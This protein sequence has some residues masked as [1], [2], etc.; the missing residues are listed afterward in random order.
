M[1][2]KAS[3]LRQI[4]CAY[5]ACVA[6]AAVVLGHCTFASPWNAW[7][8]D[9]VAT[10]VIF[11]FSRLYRNSSFYD[12]YWSVIPP[13]LAVYWYGMDAAP[14]VDAARAWLVILL[15]WC[16][17]MRLTANWATYWGGL[18][19]EDWRYPLVRERAGPKGAFWADLFGIHLFP[20]LQ[21]FVG[22]LPIYAVMTRGEEEPGLVDALAFV[23]TAG[24]IAIESIA[25]LQ[26]HAFIAKRCGNGFIRRGLWAWSRHPNYLGELLFWWGLMLFGLAAAPE[27]WWWVMPGALS[28]TAMFWFASIP[29]MEKRSLARRPAYAEYMR[30]VPALIPR[31]PSRNA[32][33]R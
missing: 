5:V 11:V 14:G 29:L 28:M 23:V 26:L 21:V 24:G 19:H 32:P 18:S 17:G 13:L 22:C 1:S 30:E 20:T 2:D 9:F 27:A 12:A 33:P 6:A 16:W 15:V 10:L 31:P 25:D 4:L 3:G 8:A 7:A